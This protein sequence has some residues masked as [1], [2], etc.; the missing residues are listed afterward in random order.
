[1][2]TEYNAVLFDMDGVLIDAREWHYAALNE[3]LGY[4]GVEITGDE[5]KAK[6]DGLTTKE[7]L[8]ILSE[9]RRIPSELHQIIGAI[10]QDR[11]LRIAASNCFPIVAHQILMTRLKSQGIKVGLVTNSIRKTSEFMLEYAG[12]L[13]FMDVIVTNEDVSAGKPSPEGYL[14]AMKQL[15]VMPSQT[16][17]VE[18]GTYGVQAAVAAGIEVIRVNNPQE[19]SLELLISKLP[20]LR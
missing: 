7:K 3:A 19:V 10:K 14:L 15:G 13:N 20:E 2:V 12:L 11:T 16:L 6:F 4:F 17:V 1:M 18:D 8:R 9:E 5:H